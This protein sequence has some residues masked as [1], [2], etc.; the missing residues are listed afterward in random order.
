[1]EIEEALLGRFADPLFEF[2]RVLL[3]HRE[4]RHQHPVF[5]HSR[6]L[7]YELRLETG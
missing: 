2:I 3:I 7:F 1:M 5:H 4:G 6:I